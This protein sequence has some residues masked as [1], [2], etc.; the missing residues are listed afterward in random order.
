MRP[1]WLC[2]VVATGCG[3][4]ST[5]GVGNQAPA[6]A[7]DAPPGNGSGSDAGA[8]SGTPPPSCLASWI[9]GTVKLETPGPLLNQHAT[10]DDERD[11]WLSADGLTLYYTFQAGGDDADLYR[12]TRATTSDPFPLGSRLPVSSSSDDSRS[13]LTAD[14]TI[15]VFASDRARKNTFSIDY[16]TRASTGEFLTA[17]P[18]HMTMVNMIGSS[19]LDPFLTKDGLELYF[20]PVVGVQRIYVAARPSLDS[21][22]LAPIPEP[23]VNNPA[24]GDAD[25]ALSPDRRVIVFSSARDTGTGPKGINLWYATRASTSVPFGAPKLVP[26]VNTDALDGDPMLSDDGCTLYLSSTRDGSY[27]LFSAAVELQ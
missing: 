16:A 19:R 12:A 25:P 8:D 13:S 9:N 21:E 18:D 3:F 5:P 27:D 20:A 24:G 23:T 11:P 1:I 10:G 17:G 4:K 14:G 6:D 26:G 2:V 22:F 7:T 15:M